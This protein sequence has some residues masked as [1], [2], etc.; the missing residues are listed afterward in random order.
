MGIE[1]VSISSSALEEPNLITSASS[2]FGSQSVVVTLDIK[3]D[4]AF[5]VNTQLTPTMV[6]ADP[7]SILF[8]IVL[9]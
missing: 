9:L 4:L 8:H 5:R 1:K 6:L 2:L 7:L 3:S